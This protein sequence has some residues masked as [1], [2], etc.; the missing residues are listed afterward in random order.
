MILRFA[1]SRTRFVAPF[2]VL[3]AGLVLAPCV[4]SFAQSLQTAHEEAPYPG[5]PVEQIIARVNDRVID[6]SDY[7]RAEQEL[8]QEAQQNQWTEQQIYDHK[9]NLLRDLIDNQLL[10]SRGKQL[11]ITGETQLVLR[12]DA[13]RKQ[14]H[15]ATMA[16]LQKAAEAQGVSW[17]DFKANLR[18]HIIEQEVI[19][20]EVSAHINISPAE[21]QD[22]YDQ[23][24]QDFE[25]PEEV[26]LSEILIPTANP[27]DAAQVAAAKAQVDKVYA[28][29]KAGADFA[30]LAKKD[31]GGVTAASGGDLG[32]FK[33]GQL[34][35]VLEEDTFSLKPGQFTE[36]VRTKQGFIILKVTKHTAAGV[37][38][39]SAVET[40]IENYIGMQKMQPALRAYLTHLR[41]NAYINI[42]DGYTDTGA[43]PNEMK[44][45]YSAYAPPTGH[46]KK[47]LERTRF[48][49]RGRH[50]G[51]RVAKNRKPLTR[52]QL[53]KI[54]KESAKPGRKEKVRFGRAPSEMLPPPIDQ[55]SQ[56]SETASN[57]GSVALA[58]G[59]MAAPQQQEAA[60]RK[61]RFG[62]YEHKLKKQEKH[63]KGEKKTK[64]N[65]FAEPPPTTLEKATREQQDQALGLNGDTSKI[66]KVNPNKEGPK[67]RFRNEKKEKPAATTS[68]PAPTASAGQQ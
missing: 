21:V 42:K 35:K 25:Q 11:G 51:R 16:D 57:S 37:Q 7:K 59:E 66:K 32:E 8:E 28:Q 62:R 47:R 1:L 5:T 26:R 2:V 34:A 52:E 67:R 19:R 45:I 41:E 38:P 15:L 53:A 58:P 48:R 24:K 9:A 63:E 6:S 27:D 23:H 43:S 30:T 40:Q 20:Q 14:Y 10:L 44:P 55:T 29:L 13:M 33:R 46:K 3:S 50:A 68:T 61:V 39:L 18:N 31:S 12:L 36:P 49:A 60:P 54:E 64:A 4:P 17:T 56:G 22:Y 65:P